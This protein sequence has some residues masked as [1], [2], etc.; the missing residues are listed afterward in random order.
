MT[1]L[2]GGGSSG[3]FERAD[4]L[5]TLALITVLDWLALP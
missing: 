4:Y 2:S 3:G 5:T 1:A